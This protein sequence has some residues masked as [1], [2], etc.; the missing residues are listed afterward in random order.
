MRC[1]VSYYVVEVESG[2]V[3]RRL[4]PDEPGSFTGG[5]LP[6]GTVPVGT[7]SPTKGCFYAIPSHIYVANKAPRALLSLDTGWAPRFRLPVHPGSVTDT[8]PAPRFRFL[9]HP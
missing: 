2:T 4:D 5:F 6:G 8:S 9:V 3:T 7:H 1:D